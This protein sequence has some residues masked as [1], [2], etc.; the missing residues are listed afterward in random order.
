M[1][2]KWITRSSEVVYGARPWLEIS[3]EKVELPSGRMLE[4]FHRVWITDYAILCA[5]TED[6][7]VTFHRF[8]CRG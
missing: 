1:S 6:G 8:N 3:R 4:D 2:S 7:Q 5:E